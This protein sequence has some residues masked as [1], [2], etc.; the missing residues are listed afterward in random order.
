MI[1]RITL[2]FVLLAIGGPSPAV[3]S[4]AAFVPE[5]RLT[6]NPFQAESFGSPEGMAASGEWLA[7]GARHGGSPDSAAGSTGVVYLFRRD[8]ARWQLAQV[9]SPPEEGDDV[10]TFGS[11]VALD[12]DTLLVGATGTS[13]NAGLFQGAVYAYE[14]EVGDAGRWV[15]TQ[16]LWPSD[17]DQ[18]A[19][20]GSSIELDG[21]VAAIVAFN[22]SAPHSRTAGR[23][24]LWERN[25]AGRWN[26][27]QNLVVGQSRKLEELAMSGRALAVS[28]PGIGTVFL[29][30]RVG[31]GGFVP[32][33]ELQPPAPE[34]AMQFGSALDLAGNDLLVGDYRALS[35]GAEAGHVWHFDVSNPADP[36][37]LR[38]FE[39][40]HRRRFS[41]RFGGRV[42]VSGDLILIAAGG[43]LVAADDEAFADGYDRSATGALYLYSRT[44]GTLEQVLTAPDPGAVSISGFGGALFDGTQLYVGAPGAQIGD[45]H[46]AGAAYVFSPSSNPPADLMITAVAVPSEVFPD[47]SATFIVEITNTSETAASG[48]TLYYPLLPGI[49]L[50]ELPSG[51][52]AGATVR[53]EIGT[54][55]PSG[56]AQ[57][58]FPVTVLSASFGTIGRNSNFFTVLSAHPDPNMLD[59]TVARAIFIVERPA[60]PPPPPPPQRS[61]GGQVGAAFVILLLCAGNLRFSSAKASSR[62]RRALRSHP[63]PAR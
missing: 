48:V 55:G 37:L 63:A 32:V 34:S 41:P 21:D 49:E 23:L 8:S 19:A 10:G 6:G 58:S 4:P 50:V 18:G 1:T 53:C 17:A 47:E 30:E 15:H 61:G 25:T 38:R 26:E 40:P 20:F 27:I 45:Q 22:A 33:F 7:I 3:E 46:L 29:F 16:T 11:P 24:Y 52:S 57:V 28:S 31:E 5:M 44:T 43:L 42:S 56:P 14:R 35:D 54:L 60:E 13:G 2:T 36:Q 51:C 39:A 59:N 9:L 62:A 12:G